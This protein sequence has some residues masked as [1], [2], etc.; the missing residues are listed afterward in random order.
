VIDEPVDRRFDR[1]GRHS[2][3]RVVIGAVADAFIVVGRQVEPK[4]V[5][6]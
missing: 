3:A 2:L 5:E 1:C 6:T 4:F